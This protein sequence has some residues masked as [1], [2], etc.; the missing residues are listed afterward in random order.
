MILNGIQVWHETYEYRKNAMIS[1]YDIRNSMI[2]NTIHGFYQSE[3][4]VWE[5]WK[6]KLDDYYN[7]K[8]Y[9]GEYAAILAM[10]DYLKGKNLLFSKKEKK[11]MREK[12]G[13]KY[14]YKAAFLWRM[15]EM[16]F[17]R[18]GHEAF[19]SYQKILEKSK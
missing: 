6:K 12:S 1:Y 8:D 14:Q 7:Q 19:V 4:D 17:N 16:R 3:K 2:V 15:L 5:D 11:Q 13:K 9:S 18:K 10:Q